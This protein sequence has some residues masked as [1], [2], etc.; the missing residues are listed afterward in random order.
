[1]SQWMM[2]PLLIPAIVSALIVITARFDQVLA[3]VFCLSA[4]IAMLAVDLKL[5]SMSGQ[6]IEIQYSLG[7]WPQPVA[8]SLALD[9]LSALMLVLSGIIGVLMALAAMDG[10]DDR[11]RHFH[12]LLLLQLMGFH[13]AF[14][15]HDLFNLFVYFE[16]M[17][18]SSY[19]LMVYGGGKRRLQSGLQFIAINLFGSTLFLVAVGLIYSVTGALDLA[20]LRVRLGSLAAGDRAI[21]NVGLV[22]LFAVFAIKS[23]VV[24]FH[25]WLPTAYSHTGPIVAG[26][27]ALST[28]VGVYATVRVY[29]ELIA[30]QETLFSSWV[31]GW[32]LPASLVT[33]SLGMIGVLGSRTLGQMA[34]YAS[35]ASSGAIMVS[36]GLFQNSSTIAAIYY[37]I[38]ST[39]AGALIFLVVE[40]VIRCRP[41]LTDRLRIGPAIQQSGLVGGLFMVAAIGLLGLPPLS[42][43]VG[44]LLIIQN[45]GGGPTAIWI[46]CVLLGTSLLGMMGFARAGSTLFWKSN[47][48]PPES[49]ASH[50]RPAVLTLVAAGLLVLLIGALSCSADPVLQFVEQL[51]SQLN[52]E[53][54]AKP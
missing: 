54:L 29:Y 40:V 46:A 30:G 5:L 4:T 38:H 2:M 25:F 27:F 20:D 9:R 50:G 17:L 10:Q 11:G 24:P 52:P 26:L 23:A 22:L 15:T 51:V 44:K 48:Q 37:L 45:A 12:S 36:V 21:A 3:R 6:G 8:I 39:L 53:E 18:G 14:L 31:T 16:V 41:S 42:G 1:M 47:H 35:L 19:G 49:T 28:K 7:N 34:S 13:G 32:L 43:F 33:T